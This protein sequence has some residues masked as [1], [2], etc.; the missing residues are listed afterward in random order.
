MNIMQVENRL[1]RVCRHYFEKSELFK[2][3]FTLP[4][5]SGNAE[6]SSDENAFVLEGIMANDFYAFLKVMTVCF[7]CLNDWA[8]NELRSTPGLQIDCP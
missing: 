2:T 1:F 3:T 4:S 5:G 7:V 8:L 6:G